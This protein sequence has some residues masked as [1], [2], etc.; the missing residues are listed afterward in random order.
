MGK[1]KEEGDWC[2]GNSGTR[3][4]QAEGHGVPAGKGGTLLS[5]GPSH[6]A[7]VPDLKERGC[8]KAW[9]LLD[10]KKE[11]LCFG[12]NKVAIESMALNRS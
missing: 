3:S 10:A 7:Q 2:Q 1:A 6:R 9:R 5:L 12:G 11:G 8:A 4:R